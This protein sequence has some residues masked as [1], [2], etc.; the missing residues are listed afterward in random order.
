MSSMRK[1]LSRLFLP[2]FF[3]LSACSTDFDLTGP[4]KDIPVVYAFIN[5]LD[6]A[7]YVRVEKAFLNP[8]SDARDIAQNPDSLYYDDVSVQLEVVGT[9]RVVTLERVDGNLEGFPREDGVFAQSPNYLYKV[10][11]GALALEGGE[12]LRL[13]INRGDNLDLVTAETN[14]LEPLSLRENGPPDPMKFE[15]FNRDVNFL[16]DAGPNAR[17]FDLRM[18]INYLES[19]PGEPSNLVDKT[20]TWVL[21]ARF[22][23]EN[24]D[25]SRVQISVKVQDLF[26][27]LAENIDESDELI[28]VFQSADLILTGVGAELINFLR[29]EEANL[30]LTS[31]QGI[32]E[33]TNLSEGRGIFTSR[34]TTQ[35]IDLS[36]SPITLDSLRNGSI[37]GGLNFK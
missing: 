5:V 17:L 30:G 20:V 11:A 15:I 12:E 2:I 3:F 36:L 35:R 28:R 23:R 13:T 32:P 25:Q 18:D 33:F 10:R 16:W 37:T 27:F 26:N 19:L 7:H 24:P 1:I 6:T 4:W 22:R 31:T 29:I 8:D 21:D 34:S 9:N 14:V